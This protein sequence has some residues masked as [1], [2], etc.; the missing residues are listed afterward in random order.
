MRFYN[1]VRYKAREGVLD[2]IHLISLVKSVRTHWNNEIGYFKCLSNDEYLAPCCQVSGSWR[3]R[4]GAVIIVYF[5]CWGKDYSSYGRD[6]PFFE[7]MLWFFGERTKNML[8]QCDLYQDLVIECTHFEFQRINIQVMKKC[9]L[10]E[11]AEQDPK[12]WDFVDQMNIDGLDIMEESLYKRLSIPEI[13]KIYSYELE[14]S[15]EK[16][17][18]KTQKTITSKNEWQ[19]VGPRKVII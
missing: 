1:P 3:W 6:N 11:M 9:F 13:E 4:C 10:V 15:I 14:N 7:C 17:V 5:D 12:I 2:R 16:P 8:E 18:L 19:I